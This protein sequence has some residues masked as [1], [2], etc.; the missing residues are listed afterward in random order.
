[1]RNKGITMTEST[2]KFDINVLHT[3][4]YTCKLPSTG[5]VIKMRT[6]LTKEHKAL[7]IAQESDQKVDAIEQCL[8]AC[9]ITDIDINELPVADAEYLFLTMYTNSNA[10]H[11]IMAEYTCQRKKSDEELEE[12][13]KPLPT[14]PED[15][16]LDDIDIEEFEAIMASQNNA[17]VF[18]KVSTPEE[19]IDVM[20]KPSDY[21]CGEHIKSLIR[22]DNAFVPTFDGSDTVV[23]NDQ[24]T[25]KLKHPNIKHF[26]DNDPTTAEGLFNLASES[27][28]EVYVG[29]VVY[30]Y[31]E[32]RDQEML[33]PIMD[34][35]SANSFVEIKD[36]ID[37]TPRLSVFVDVK[38]PKCHS[39]EKVLLRGIDDFFV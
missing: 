37:K 8:K 23:I 33:I 39:E 1:M 15:S 4:H 35:I 14:L 34:E 25:I 5:A 26:E 31:K 19:V 28:F 17:D 21:V 29:D 32:L 10:E 6:L 12:M 9:I 7:L 22:L 38:C 11:T 30:T 27:I 16:E 20:L 13:K 36:F 18:S 24:V 2:K 3:P